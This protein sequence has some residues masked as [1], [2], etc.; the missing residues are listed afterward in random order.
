MSLLLKALNKAS[1]EQR[2]A[3][4]PAT[5]TAGRE[6]QIGAF[7]PFPAPP[8]RRWLV[9]AT[10]SLAALAA[11]G[12]GIYVYLETLAPTPIAAAVPAAS[13]AL[14]PPP[15]AG[16][17]AEAPRAVPAVP[18]PPTA[19]R[20]DN[21]PP[22]PETAPLPEDTGDTPAPPSP[23]A[24]KAPVQHGAIKIS[25]G[26]GPA[27]VDPMLEQAYQALG[28]GRDDAARTLYQRLLAAQPANPDALLGLAVIAG[29]Q[30]Q[31]AQSA[32]YYLR[33]LEADPGNPVAQAGL[34]G[35]MGR[36]DPLT[37]EARLKRLLDSQPAPFLYFAL[38]NLYAGQG[39]WPAAEQAYFE[40][41]R[42]APGNP[43]YAFNLAV[44]LDHLGQ[45]KAAL[46][47]YRQARQL[48]RTR[49]GAGFDPALAAARIKRLGGGS[50]EE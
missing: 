38:G 44:S 15:P 48:A 33:A 41:C 27:P 1:R 45:P 9:P 23:A 25:A 4:A 35:I 46:S 5:G 29:R 6:G 14:S 10:A 30:G 37:S 17:V 11:L 3:A 36:A 22:A 2:G 32:D 49:G 50:G 19:A 13:P 12:W 16:P 47:Y 21:T 8:R 18:S 42:K 31:G 43:D 40:A 34:I 20:P 24:D 7:L 39:R 28:Q 26:N